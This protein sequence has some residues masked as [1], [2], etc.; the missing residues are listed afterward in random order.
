MAMGEVCPQLVHND[1]WPQ[2]HELNLLHSESRS[3]D[4]REMLGKGSRPG[5]RSSATR[6]IMN[7]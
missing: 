6:Q 3:A 2:F 7:R 5:G 1:R 4:N